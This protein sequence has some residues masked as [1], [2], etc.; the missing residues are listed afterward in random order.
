LEHLAKDTVLN[1]SE[2]ERLP[3]WE[4]LVDL[5]AKHRY[6]GDAHWA[7]KPESV[8]KIEDA[9]IDGIERDDG[10]EMFVEYCLPGTDTRFAKHI[11]RGEEFVMFKQYSDFY[12]ETWRF[13]DVIN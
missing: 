9:I 12:D 13:G 5:A 2:T 3:L 7:M 6:F 10:G 11:A 1:V 8:A 4:A